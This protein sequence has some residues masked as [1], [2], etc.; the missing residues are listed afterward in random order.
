MKKNNY[1]LL[2]DDDKI[3]NYINFRLF[4]KLKSSC[5]VTISHNGAEALNH[6]EKH[7]D[8]LPEFI[9]LDIEM[10]IMNGIKFLQEFTKLDRADKDTVKIIIL[11]A[12]IHPDYI[13]TL[14]KYPIHSYLT[15]PLTPEKILAVMKDTLSCSKNIHPDTTVLIEA[16]TDIY[17]N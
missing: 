10:P 1:I 8:A 11:T 4:E 3:N 16:N 9:F 6:I 14:N 13:Q 12:S 7:P 15:K 17:S 5:N 2:I